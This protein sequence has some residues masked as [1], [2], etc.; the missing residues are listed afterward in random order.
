MAGA[1]VGRWL[2]IA[3]RTFFEGHGQPDPGWGLA[4]TSGV[5][6]MAANHAPIPLLARSSPGEG[7][8]A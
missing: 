1:R 3:P 5:R 2:E 8:L 7:R 6:G 4:I